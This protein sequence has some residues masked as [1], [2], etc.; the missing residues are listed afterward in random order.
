MKRIFNSKNYRYTNPLH[1]Q[2]LLEVLGIIYKFDFILL[3]IADLV[4]ILRGCLEKEEQC[5]KVIR[6]SSL[7]Y[8]KEVINN[9][10]DTLI[11]G[12]KHIIKAGLRHFD[13]NKRE[14]AQRLKIV[15]DTY[16]KP[17]SMTS[18]S[19]DAATV[20]INNLLRELN[21]KYASDVQELELGPWLAELQAQN[22]EFENTAKD[23]NVKSAEKPDFNSVDI[24]K[25]SDKAYK[26]I[27]TYINS[28]IVVDKETSYDQFVSELNTLIKHY[29]DLLAQ[30]LGNLEAGKERKQDDGD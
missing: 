19:F 4:D 2:F 7:S 9:A 11:V 12:I 17:V 3:K 15:F 6:K 21:G 10:R 20:T 25:E 22:D 29:N 14:A 26:D 5:Y 1:I 23:Y 8:I 30:H 24:R 16:D 27:I 18:L 13:K 28:L